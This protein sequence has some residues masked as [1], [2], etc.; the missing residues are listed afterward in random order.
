VTEAEH[1]FGPWSQQL[2]SFGPDMTLGVNMPVRWT[3]AGGLDL[4]LDNILITRPQLDAGA[5]MSDVFARL[6]G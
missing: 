3:E 6:A 2:G 5:L 1:T 4:N